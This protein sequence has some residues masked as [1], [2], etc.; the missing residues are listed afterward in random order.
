MGHTCRNQESG[1]VGGAVWRIQIKCKVPQGARAAQAGRCNPLALPGES[2][3][4]LLM[5]ICLGQQHWHL[6]GTCSKCGILGPTLDLLSIPLP[7]YRW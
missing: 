5:G 6:L 7:F 2:L 4:L 3:P 1:G